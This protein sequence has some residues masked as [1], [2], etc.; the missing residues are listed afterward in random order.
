[1]SS[2]VNRHISRD[3]GTKAPANWN[4]TALEQRPQDQM[5]STRIISSQPNETSPYTFI[6]PDS[7]LHLP[8]SFQI[9][10]DARQQNFFIYSNEGWRLQEI[11]IIS[12]LIRDFSKIKR[13]CTLL[14]PWVCSTFATRS[15]NNETHLILFDFTQHDLCDRVPRRYNDIGPRFSATPPAMPFF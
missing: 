8:Y 6:L 5:I 7:T 12:R 1:M 11:Y 3:A 15:K 9:F 13:T 14:V 2:F 4:N 10:T